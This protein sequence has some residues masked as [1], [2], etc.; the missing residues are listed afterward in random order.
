[1]PAEAGVS[2]RHAGPP[3]TASYAGS[4]YPNHDPAIFG[5]ASGLRMIEARS[6]AAQRAVEMVQRLSGIPRFGSNAVIVSGTRTATGNPML[7]GG[8]QTGLA[9]PGDFSGRE[10]H[11]PRP[12]Q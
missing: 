6:T 12:E 7:Y 3:V 4:T 5:D 8:P 1:M 2:P 9:A 10:L 11:D